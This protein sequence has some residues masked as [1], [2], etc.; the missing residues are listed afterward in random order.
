MVAGKDDS[1][2]V[3]H[4]TLT[5]MKQFLAQESPPKLSEADT[6]AN[7][8]DPILAALGW[9]GIGL[10]VREYY[11][12]NSQEF[13]DFVMADK[14]KRVLAI[15]AKA[16]QVDLSEKAAAQLVQYC[17]V[18]GIEW[19]ALINAR[20][21]RFFNTYLKGDLAA[22]LVLRLDLLA[23]NSD[24]E[25]AALFEQLWLLSRESMTMPTG[26]HTWL[27]QQRMDQVLRSVMFNSASPAIKA[28]R[29]CL[30]ENDIR[31]S[32]EDIVQWFRTQLT[33]NITPLPSMAK[34]TLTE[35]ATSGTQ[36]ATRPALSSSQPRATGVHYLLPCAK[37]GDLDAPGHLRVWLDQNM[38]G[39]HES[40]PGRK[41]LR[42]GD[43][44]CFYVSGQGVAATATVTGEATSAL[45]DDEVP[46]GPT[47]HTIYRVPLTDVVWL[48][49]PLPID[50]TI[51]A[52]LD[53]FR[54]KRVD[55]SW[56]WLVQTTHK[57][58]AHD[59]QILTGQIGIGTSADVA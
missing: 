15:E 26:V 49:L 37:W 19:A 4:A 27:E 51:R 12:K 9:T 24:A 20:E 8:I 36:S 35:P 22:K 55:G 2:G 48:P 56:S 52:S 21:L 43:R 1:K 39:M 14:G 18:E 23:F 59:Y 41:N 11:V 50:A 29:K 28:I 3:I 7:F 30:A 45:R 42:A 25:Y 38:W 40:T 47:D 53:A 5:A 16:L 54:G 6:K 46:T 32:S 58:T 31:A 13:I 10:V 57:L 44:V 34:H 17:V 33:P